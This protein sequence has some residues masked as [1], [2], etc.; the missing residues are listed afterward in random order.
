MVIE[1]ERERKK[2]KM[3]I[4]GC[5]YHISKRETTEISR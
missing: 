3:N 1:R 2:K 5:S 4:N